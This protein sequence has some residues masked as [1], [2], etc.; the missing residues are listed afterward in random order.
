MASVHQKH[1]LANVA[2]SVL[3][4]RGV[5]LMFFLFFWGDE[6]ACPQAGKRRVKRAA[7][8][9]PGSVKPAFTVF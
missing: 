4:G 8:N 2:V 1:P 6:G 9:K 3:A 7:V 5:E